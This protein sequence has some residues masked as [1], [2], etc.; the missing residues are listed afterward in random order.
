MKEAELRVWWTKDGVWENGKKSDVQV[1]TF[2]ASRRHCKPCSKSRSQ[3]LLTPVTRWPGCP[4][5]KKVRVKQ[6]YRACFEVHCGRMLDAGHCSD[7]RSSGSHA[8]MA[9]T[10]VLE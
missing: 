2:P 4:R 9:M 7:Q 5:E 6:R 3:R 10:W 8:A 1:A